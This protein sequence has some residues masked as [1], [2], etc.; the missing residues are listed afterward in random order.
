MSQTPATYL[1]YGLWADLVVKYTSDIGKRSSGRKYF[2]V[3]AVAHYPCL[4]I[5]VT[6]QQHS[7]SSLCMQGPGKRLRPC[8]RLCFTGARQMIAVLMIC[9]RLSLA[10]ARQMTAALGTTW[11]HE[12]HVRV[13]L[14][15]SQATDGGSL[16]CH[17]VATTVMTPCEVCRGSSWM[18]AHMPED[19]RNGGVW[20]GH[21]LDVHCTAQHSTEQPSPMYL[22]RQCH[23]SDV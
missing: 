20:L 6:P 21:C 19:R 7:N 9:P 12:P 2:I 13:Q 15:L 22:S 18:Y 23:Q 16:P 10:G 14:Q 1:L 11:A 5:S 4:T 8:L 3:V 17:A